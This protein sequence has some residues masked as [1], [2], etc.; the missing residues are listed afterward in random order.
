MST[1]QPPNPSP[2]LLD[3]ARAL[4]AAHGT[5]MTTRDIAKRMDCSHEWVR[6]FIAGEIPNPGVLTVERFIEAIKA[7]AN[8]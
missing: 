6:R 2:S 7:N 8:V 5:G 3:V 4:Y 1:I